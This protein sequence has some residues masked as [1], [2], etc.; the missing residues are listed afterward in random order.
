MALYGGWD[1]G[2]CSIWNILKVFGDDLQT[3]VY[4]DILQEITGGGLMYVSRG[5]LHG[6]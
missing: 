6:V 5:F 4:Q 1:D 2:I 3:I